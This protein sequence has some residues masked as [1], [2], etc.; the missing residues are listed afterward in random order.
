MSQAVQCSV[1]KG[2]MATRKAMPSV[3][4][5]Q[6]IAA[7]A[8]RRPARAVRAQAA[9]AAAPATVGASSSAPTVEESP[10]ANMDVVRHGRR[11]N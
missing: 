10:A 4:V 1:A 9:A 5:A 11:L 2:P 3:P 6:K 8:A 7:Q